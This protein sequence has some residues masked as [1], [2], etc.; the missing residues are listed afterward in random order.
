MNNNC[1]RIL[2]INGDFRTELF[3]RNDFK[4]V[5]QLPEEGEVYAIKKQVMRNGVL[6]FVL[7]ELDGGTFPN[8]RPVTFHHSRFILLQPEPEVKP[9]KETVSKIEELASLW[10]K[11]LL[12]NYKIS[13]N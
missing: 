11:E 10:R 3:N 5:T 13:E 12:N 4:Y 1:I 8:G 6:G 2:C 9:I 7:N